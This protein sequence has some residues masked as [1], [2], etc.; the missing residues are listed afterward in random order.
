ME[1]IFAPSLGDAFER[2]GMRLNGREPEPGRLLRF[3][4][5][6]RD[7]DKA[8]WCRMFPDGAGAVFGDWRGGDAFAWQQRDR[9]APPPTA[10]ERAAAR[11]KADA[12]RLEAERE[13]AAQHAKAAKT[14]A[15]IW[16]ESK[17]LAGPHDYLTRKGVQSHGARLDHGGALVVPV[18]DAKGRIQ[19]LQFIDPKGGKRFLPGGA[20]KSGRLVLGELLDGKPIAL[21]EGFATAASVREATGLP[22]VVGFSGSNLQHVAASLRQQCPQSRLIVAG[23]LDA[24]GVGRKY[25]DAARA[26]HGAAIAVL[27]TFT[28]GRVAGDWN[29]LHQAEDADVVKRQIEGVPPSRFRLLTA[30]DL[31]AL[32]PLRWRVRDVLP[33]SGLAA[34]FGP[35][36]SGKSFLVIDLALSVARGL[37]WFGH[38][39]KGCPVCYAALEGE[40]GI[41]GR[42]AAYTE[43]HGETGNRVRYLVQRF[44]LLSP[45]DV[46]DLASAIH[47]AGGAGGVVILDT[48][49]RAA[50]GSDENDSK[51]MGAIITAA[52]LLQT[53]VGGLVVLVHHVGK[54]KSRGM[55]G[56]SSLHAALDAA[57]EVDRDDGRR[58]WKLHK[59]KDGEDGQAHPFRLDVVDVGTD[60]DGEPLTSCVVAPAADMGEAVRRM[61]PPKSGNQRIV[62]DV[63]DE[64]LRKSAHYG[65]AGAPPGRPCI[66]LEAAVEYSR[67]RLVC[68][69]KRQTERA[70]AAIRGL[71]GRGLLEHRDGWLW[72]A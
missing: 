13:R 64:P 32:P 8:G 51:D 9:D 59:A 18:H 16:G 31:A 48:L 1:T 56:H 29:D 71:V 20:M 53:E 67:G 27:P 7:D 21:A 72:C 70:Q 46:A 15:T 36:G 66:T 14:A 3:S 52:K 41:A 2:A 5:N 45:N 22:V 47:D 43:R 35:S 40:A 25:A 68:E 10:A 55:R 42:V 6:G 57:I 19:S 38:R 54:D 62:W 33:E 69:P 23:D 63:L 37:A 24:N 65:Q 50:P 44:N 60:D 58:E 11:A 28:D 49:N 39:V 34:V 61:M 4:T 17:P 30:G 26:A 12:A